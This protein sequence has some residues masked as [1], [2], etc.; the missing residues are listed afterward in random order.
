[1]GFV[2]FSLLSSLS[3][4]SQKTCF[5]VFGP[6]SS[7]GKHKSSAFSSSSACERRRMDAAG[8]HWRRLLKAGACVYLMNARGCTSAATCPSEPTATRCHGGLRRGSM[9]QIHTSDVSSDLLPFN[10]I[11]NYY[12]GVYLFYIT[13]PLPVARGLI[14]S[15]VVL[16][17]SASCQ[18]E[19]MMQIVI[20]WGCRVLGC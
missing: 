19:V 17:R 5:M 16:L 11:N 14:T 13:A 10:L 20:S 18:C 3:L 15:F 8:R 4:G 6:R 12:I 2:P 7:Y 1:M 9:P